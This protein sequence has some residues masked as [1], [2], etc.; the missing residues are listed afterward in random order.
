MAKEHGNLLAK[1]QGN[2]LC[3]KIGK[4]KEKRVVTVVLHYFSIAQLLGGCLIDSVPLQHFEA[5][6]KTYNPK[7]YRFVEGV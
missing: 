6:S 3:S 7:C 5:A 4:E 2:A 1:E